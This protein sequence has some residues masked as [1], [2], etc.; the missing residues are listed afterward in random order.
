MT[1][2]QLKYIHN[3]KLVMSIQQQSPSINSHAEENSAFSYLFIY[4]LSSVTSSQTHKT[5][6]FAIYF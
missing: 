3:L 5:V 4:Y 2:K 6:H 1:K